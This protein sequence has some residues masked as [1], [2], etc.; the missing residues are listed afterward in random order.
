[1]HVTYHYRDVN[2][3]NCLHAIK[4]YHRKDLIVP[5]VKA[6]IDEHLI[7]FVDSTANTFLVPIPMHR[8]R[9]W[10]RGYNHAFHIAKAYGETLI[11]RVETNL[12]ARSANSPQQA[13]LRRKKE[14]EKN[15]RN[16][17]LVNN[18]RF[19]ANKTNII[20][21][22]DTTTTHATLL[23]AKKVLEKSGFASV[24]ALVLAH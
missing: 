2:V 4:Y 1:M 16:V 11:I 24:R 20:L 14:R 6:T 15:V 5:I 10:S 12:L 13:K 18:H 9:L 8:K 23:E 3:R 17:F 22:D 21:I 7:S 19:D